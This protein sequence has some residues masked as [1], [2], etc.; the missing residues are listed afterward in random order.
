[1]YLN[2][3]MFEEDDDD[4]SDWEPFQLPTCVEVVKWFCKNCT[5]VNLDDVVHCDVCL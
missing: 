3:G 4:D 2:Q 5:M 1:M